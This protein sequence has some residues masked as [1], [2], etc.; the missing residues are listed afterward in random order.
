MR[1]LSWK[2][3]VIFALAMLTVIFVACGS[4]TGDTR[5]PLLCTPETLQEIDFLVLNTDVR[6]AIEQ[7]YMYQRLVEQ[8]E[9]Y[10]ASIAH[11]VTTAFL[12][13]LNVPL[14]NIPEWFIEMRDQEVQ[15]ADEKNK[16]VDYGFLNDAFD[17]FILEDKYSQYADP[18]QKLKLFEAVT[19]GF[20]KAL[21]DPFAHLFTP[22]LVDL[23]LTKSTGT[24]SGIG[25]GIGRNKNNEWEL[26]SIGEG[27]PAERA[28]LQRHDIVRKVDGKSVEGCVSSR[29]VL[30][31]RGKVGTEVLFT[32]ERDGEELEVSIVRDIIKFNL[33]ESWPA[34]ELPDGRGSTNKTLPYEFPLLTRNGEESPGIAYIVIKSFES[35]TLVDLSYVL[36]QMSWEDKTGLIVDLRSNPG[37][38]LPVIEVIVGYFL[39]PKATILWREEASG[40]KTI[41]R[42]VSERQ[43]F[44]EAI[45]EFCVGPNIVPSDLPVVVL[46]NKNSYSGSEV[47]AGALQDNGRATLVGERTGGKGTVNRYFSL[48]NGDYGELYITTEI[49]LTPNGN[50]IEPLYETEE[51]GLLPDIVIEQPING[52]SPDND[53]N[54]FRALDILEA[55][56]N[57]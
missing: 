4:N 22:M 48:R 10:E 50:H 18:E 26:N 29:L 30:N 23:G 56:R 9:D 14:S 28:G 20:I 32:I 41:S 37:G 17:R 51:G 11:S 44:R 13:V 57:K 47:M 43:C 19:S 49:W 36:E 54:I 25:A 39:D 2:V 24:F 8:G 3:G 7:G 27:G 52:F 16:A 55:Q 31:V 6:P 40:Q 38:S 45:G 34:I 1:I 33:V 35:Q 15:K 53:E 42:T 5:I 21:G 12:N 46:I